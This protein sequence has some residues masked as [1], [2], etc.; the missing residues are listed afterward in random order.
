MQFLK[1]NYY[2][3]A[4]IINGRR[5]NNIKTSIKN[6]QYYLNQKNMN[7]FNKIIL[8]NPLKTIFYL[9]NY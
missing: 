2:K 8:I 6:K 9:K 4:I 7:F 1:T 3:Y 5:I